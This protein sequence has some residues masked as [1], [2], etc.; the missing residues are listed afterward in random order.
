MPSKSNPSR[1]RPRSE[2]ES[3]EDSDVLRASQRS[4]PSTSD[5]A[6]RVRT[7]GYHTESQPESPE[8]GPSRPNGTLRRQS[9]LFDDEDEEASDDDRAGPSEFQPGAIVRVKLTNF[10]TYENAEFF[11]G[12]NLNMVIGPNG[13]GKSSLVCAICLGLGW[14]PQHLG[15][16]GQVGEFVKH[17]MSDAIVE[18]E[19]QRRPDEPRNHVVRLRILRDGNGRE[20]W[21]NGKK[22]SLK[23]VQNLTKSLSIQIDNLCQFLPQDKVSEFAALSPVDLLQ[24]TQRAAAPEYM[25]EWHEALKKL[26]KEQKALEIQ[27]EN[28]KEQL[29]RLENRQQ[30]LH[31]EVERLQERIKIQEKV[32]LLE[33]TV[34]FVEYRL[35]LDQ[36]KKFKNDKNEAHMRFKELA[37]RIAPTL[38]SIDAK[39]SYKAQIQVVV[40]EREQALKFA[41]RDADAQARTIEALTENVKNIE[42]QANSILVAERKR[43]GELVKIEKNI[44]DMQ[45][46]QKDTVI[47]FNAAEWNERVV[48]APIAYFS[49]SLANFRFSVQKSMRFGM[50]MRRLQIS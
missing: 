26:R 14:G 5:S 16:A 37:A 9:N 40:K 20:W 4:T 33:K 15:R 25:L 50:P 27:D 28:D 2:I 10:V 1:R 18:I 36:H 17:N 30:N 7:N 41:E 49:I 35:A 24:Q 42:Q 13:T 32:S 12:P 39:E 11:P 21:L 47:E 48:S 23:Q 43:K 8:P 6:K 44:R 46:R 34:P 29:G 19:L 38:Q 45:A 31:A 3:D 22:T